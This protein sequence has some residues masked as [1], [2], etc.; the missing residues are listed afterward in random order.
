MLWRTTTFFQIAYIFKSV[1]FWR[2]QSLI[3]SCIYRLKIV[4]KCIDILYIKTALFVLYR[5]IH[6][7]VTFRSLC[8]QTLE[9]LVVI[10]KM[11]WRIGSHLEVS[12]Y[13][14]R[15]ILYTY[16]GAFTAFH[17]FKLFIKWNESFLQIGKKE[18]KG[19]ENGYL[20]ARR[21]CVHL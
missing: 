4:L 6:G 18:R 14:Q 21:G 5:Y 3:S 8:S 12:Y 2:Y 13:L 9:R 16:S 7:K 11:L 10:V 15:H 1:I 19:P 17:F 20:L